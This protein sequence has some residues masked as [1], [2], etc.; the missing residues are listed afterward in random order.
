MSDKPHACDFPPE[1]GVVRKV[2]RTHT[3]LPQ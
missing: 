2:Y 1:L 3:T